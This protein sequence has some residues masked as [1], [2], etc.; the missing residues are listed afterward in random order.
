M[1]VLKRWVMALM[2]GVAG[3]SLE[4]PEK[5]VVGLEQYWWSWSESW[6]FGVVW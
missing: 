3:I 1:L 2:S 5:V 6:L 4:L